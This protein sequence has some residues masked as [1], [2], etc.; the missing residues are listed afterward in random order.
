LRKKINKYSNT[1]RIVTACDSAIL[2]NQKDVIIETMEGVLWIKFPD[3]APL[4]R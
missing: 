4:K 1:Y 2:G 3:I